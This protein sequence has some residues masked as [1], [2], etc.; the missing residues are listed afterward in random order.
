VSVLPSLHPPLTLGSQLTL[1]ALRAPERVAIAM[2]DGPAQTYRELDGLTNRLANALLGSGI[3][4]GERV[5]I[6][7]DN[8]LEYLDTYLACLKSG[9]VIVQINVRH[10]AFEAKYQLEDS[11]AAALFFDDTVAERV[12]GLELAGQLRLLA[13]TGKER[14]SG[15]LSFAQLVEGGSTS[16]LVNDLR[17]EDLAVIGYTSG[18]TGFPKGA[19]LTHRSIRTLGATNALTNRYVMQSRQIFPLSLSF[20][21]GI[22]AHILT[23]LYVGGTS[24]IMKNWDTERLVDAIDDYSA[25]FTIL[26]SPPIVEFAQIVRSRHTNL[27]SLVSVLHS[28][29]KAPEEHLELLVDTIGPRLVEGWGMTENSGGLIAATTGE[30]YSG[31]IPG[32][33]SSTGRAA[34]DTVVRIIDD[35]GNLLPADGNSV[36]QLIVFSGALARGYW[37]NPEATANSFVDGWYHTGDLGHIDPD[38]YITILD[39]RNDLILSGGMNVYP[40]EIERILLSVEGVAEAAVVAGPHERW[41]QTPVA[42]VRRGDESVSAESIIAHCRERLASYKLPTDIRFMDALPMNASGKV[43]KSVLRESIEPGA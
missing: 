20:T 38:G 24:Y 16:G 27:D 40:S 3:L 11:G 19:E 41:G 7:M 23:H 35:E 26:P 9:H 17:P 22:P 1:G 31:K 34:P 13:T 25:S 28:T 18:T 2:V 21:A 30:D 33:F 15:A 39:R 6:W 5:A 36:G 8:S 37:Q 32:I 10:T 42:F 14:V 43:L 29:A 12:E 4:P